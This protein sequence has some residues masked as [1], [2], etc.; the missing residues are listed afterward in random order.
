MRISDALRRGRAMISLAAGLALLILIPSAAGHANRR[1][2]L[3]KRRFGKAE[4]REEEGSHWGGEAGNCLATQQ[5]IT[6]MR[7]RR[8]GDY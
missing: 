8:Q 5:T 2:R 7:T 6:P 1:G 3:L 4:L